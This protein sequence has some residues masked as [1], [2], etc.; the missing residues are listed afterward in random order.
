[1][2]FLQATVMMIWGRI[3]EKG[4]CIS[5][6]MKDIRISCTNEWVVLGLWKLKTKQ[7]P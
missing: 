2:S 4:D 1:M 5:L 3:V 7:D 6:V